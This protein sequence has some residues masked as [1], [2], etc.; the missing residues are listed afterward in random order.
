MLAMMIRRVRKERGSMRGMRGERV[1]E[2]SVLITGSGLG[3][4]GCSSVLGS[5]SGCRSAGAVPRLTPRVRF[6]RYPL[7]SSGADGL[8]SLLISQTNIYVG[9]SSKSTHA[10]PAVARGGGDCIER[11]PRSGLS[12]R[13]RSRLIAGRPISALSFQHPS[14]LFLV[15]VSSI[16][17][18]C[19]SLQLNF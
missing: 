16:V 6:K 1:G 13:R 8:H 10:S 19:S 4:S 9:R 18:S 17:A 15:R 7:A 2:G 3:W 5:A 11:L 12:P 14:P